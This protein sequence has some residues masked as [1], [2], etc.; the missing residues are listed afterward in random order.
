MPCQRD[1][2]QLVNAP[3][4]QSA[5]QILG[6]GPDLYRRNNTLMD[7]LLDRWLVEIRQT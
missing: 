3:H 2:D 4:I 1:A 5:A 7:A 6:K